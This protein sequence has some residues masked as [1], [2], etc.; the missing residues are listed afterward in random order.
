MKCNGSI[1]GLV[2]TELSSE[3]LPVADCSLFDQSE[4]DLIALL[5]DR[6]QSGSFIIGDGLVVAEL[7]GAGTVVAGSDDDG[8]DA[9]IKVGIDQ[10]LLHVDGVLGDQEILILGSQNLAGLG[11]EFINAPYEGLLVGSTLVGLLQNRVLGS[12]VVYSDQAGAGLLQRP[13]GNG[14]TMNHSV[15]NTDK[16]NSHF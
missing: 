4:L 10:D 13:S 15:V 7:C 8:L 5:H 1:S 2:V 16:R 12:S 3:L 6:F 11:E 9:G 14:L